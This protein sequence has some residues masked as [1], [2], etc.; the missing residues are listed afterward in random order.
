M[1]WYFFLY[2]SQGTLYSA[3]CNMCIDI[4]YVWYVE[5]NISDEVNLLRYEK[6]H[7]SVVEI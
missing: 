2:F 1:A 4:W 5:L 3:I 6:L 7:L